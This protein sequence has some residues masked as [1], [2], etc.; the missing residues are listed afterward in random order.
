MKI[1][2]DTN[3]FLAVALR[4]PEKDALATIVAGH[5]LIAPEVLPF[6]VGNAL[7]S[8]LKKGSLEPES[9]QAA[10]EMLAMVPVELHKVNMAQALMIAVEYKI[11]AYDAY[12]LECALRLRAPLLTL[13][14]GMQRI[15]TNLSIRVLELPK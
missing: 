3:T 10:W 9:V 8:M 7:S 14:K 6:E 5:E 4:E 1:V 13:D 2:A 12:F 11:Y 15:A